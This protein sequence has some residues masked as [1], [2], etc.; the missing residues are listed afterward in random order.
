MSSWPLRPNWR[1]PYRITYSFLTEIFVSRS[2]KEQRRAKRQKPRKRVEFT[3]TAAD[4]RFRA[5]YRALSTGQGPLVDLPEITR[6][7]K[8]TNAMAAAGTS[9]TVAA[10]PP[11][12]T[13]GAKVML[14]N[15]DRA[16][17]RTILS[18]AAGVITF[19]AA[20]VN[21]WP[22]ATLICP[23]LSVRL[24]DDQATTQHTTRVNEA[25]VAFAVEPGSEP[26]L[27]PGP[28][29]TI[30]NGREV[31]L[32]HGNWAG[33]RE[34]RFQRATRVVDYGV[35]RIRTFL[36][37]AFGTSVRA[38]DCLAKTRA[39]AVR[40]L[41]FFLR[42]RG[43]LGEFYVPS[44]FDDIRLAGGSSTVYLFVDGTDFHAAY[45][46]DAVHKALSFRLKDGTRFYRT[47][48]GLTVQGAQSRIQLNQAPPVKLTKEN[49]E[50]ISWLPVMRLA[51]DDLAIE[52]VTDGVAQVRMNYQTLPDQP[53]E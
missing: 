13:P 11:W 51:A 21:P 25:T 18:A 29:E 2:G 10:I 46:G 26:A 7:V 34:V 52:W 47:I 33:S 39:E 23:A 48:V 3:V 5:L 35:G 41:D 1:D 30:W 43:R 24:D 9:F 37:V 36:P 45:A 27:V 32:D 19:T 31:F 49:T 53:P 4:D 22:R 28:A 50:V 17:P 14:V 16:Q 8:S 42:Q 6:S 40:L 20:T 44:D 15:D 12:A 38:V